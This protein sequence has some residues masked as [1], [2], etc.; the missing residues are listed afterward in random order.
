MH[1][2][3]SNSIPDKRKIYTHKTKQ[4]VIYKTIY[5][6]IVKYAAEISPVSMWI[7]SRVTAEVKTKQAGIENEM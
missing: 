5:L 4:N 7:K 3:T 2:A 1:N 6:A